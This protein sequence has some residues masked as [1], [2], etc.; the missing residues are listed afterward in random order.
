LALR[1]DRADLLGYGSF[2]AYKLETEMAK[3]PEAV[4]NLLMQVW[5]P[6]KAAAEADALVLTEM[7]QADG[8]N[9]DLEPWDW[10]YYSEKRRKAE[11]DLDEA[12]LKPYL[13]LERM[14]EA[15]FTCASRLFGLAFK[16]IDVAMYHPDARAW[17][18]TR[19]GKHLAVFVG[20]YFARG[21]K[22]S[23]A[24]CSAMRSQQRLAGD[25]RPIV[26]NVCNFAKRARC[27][28]N[29]VTPCTRC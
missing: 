27:F 6:A 19:D 9:G 1:E 20:D 14:I 10:R 5:T 13:Q 23:G 22:R 16:P 29:L 15:S 8:I 12:E 11:H 24:W 7:M 26:V 28:M 25:I 18:V 21:S 3:T 17:E 4:E 2:A